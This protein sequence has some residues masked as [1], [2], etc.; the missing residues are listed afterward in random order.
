MVFK[1]QHTKRNSLTSLFHFGKSKRQSFQGAQV[2]STNDSTTQP[3]T[4]TG[5]G[6]VDSIDI[7][8]LRSSADTPKDSHSPTNVDDNLA[9]AKLKKALEAES[10]QRL[11][12]EKLEEKV[13]EFK[14]KVRFILVNMFLTLLNDVD[15]SVVERGSG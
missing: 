15:K 12:V 8:Q 3:D 11:V 10:N 5:R 2:Q 9:T 6:G 4:E 13:A 14:R 1:A 7:C